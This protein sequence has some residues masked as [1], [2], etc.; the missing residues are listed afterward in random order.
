MFTTGM[1][2]SREHQ[3][4]INDVEA[5]EFGLLLNFAYTSTVDIST[6]NVQVFISFSYIL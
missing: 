5:E 1:V 3:V 6:E 2:E 4:N